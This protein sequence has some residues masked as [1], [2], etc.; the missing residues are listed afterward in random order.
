MPEEKPSPEGLAESKSLNHQRRTS[1]SLKSADRCTTESSFSRYTPSLSKLLP[2]YG[3]YLQSFFSKLSDVYERL[4]L[5]RS[6]ALFQQDT[7]HVESRRNDEVEEL[8]YVWAK[9][10][11]R[12]RKI[13]L[14]GGLII[15]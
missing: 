8:L 5:G 1:D 12:E 6:Q 14:S 7:E 13:L 15:H 10:R 11:V 2:D 3:I 4:H 9:E